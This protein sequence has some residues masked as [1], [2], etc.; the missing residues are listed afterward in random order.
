MT[1]ATD[2]ALNPADRLTVVLDEVA[3]QSTTM[4]GRYSAEM[5][6]GLIATAPEGFQVA[7]LSARITDSRAERVQQLL[8]GL[9]ELRQTAVPARELRE[10]WLHTITTIPVRGFVHATSLMAPLVRDPAPGDQVT[11]TVHGLE[12][13]SDRSERKQ[14]W[15]ERA[16]RRAVARAH[17]IVVPSTAVAE[18]LVAAGAP[19]DIVRVV[20]PAPSAAL[21]AAAAAP[22]ER[23]LTL[24]DSYVLALTQPGGLRHAERLIETVA[25]P[26]M[27]DVKVVVA[28][29][30]EWDETRL[31]ALAV[32]AGI[33]AGRL[34]MLGDLSHADLASVYRGALA[35]LHVAE[36]D[37]L[38][39]TLLEAAALGTATV[40]LSNRSLDE[41]AG[42][43]SVSVD[44]GAPELAAAL[45]TLLDAPDEL[46]RLR[47]HAQD[48]AQAFT[49]E[50]AAQQVWQLHADL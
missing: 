13:F 14:R 12:S 49:W 35:H 1:D 8:P 25:D 15:F 39:L 36:H 41:I 20:H 43:A 3:E 30:V 42:D 2:A 7:G 24:P 22:A 6:R 38:G 31:A 48:R 16:L 11:V 21:L 26:A 44:G 17:G 37:A 23:A 47:L 9:V 40:H 19:D 50:A 33:P 32:E 18:D 45:A 29:P 28:G 27:P 4:V 5:A 34:V 46:A 10:A